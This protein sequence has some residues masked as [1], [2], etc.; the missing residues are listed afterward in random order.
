MTARAALAPVLLVLGCSA[1]TLPAPSI[2][3]VSPATMVASTPTPVTVVVDA[4]LANQVDFGQGTLIFD[5]GMVVQI[6]SQRLGSG[7]Y[8]PDGRVQ[9]TLPTV[10]PT[11][12]YLVTVTLEDGRRA[13]S[14][15]GF[16]VTDGL[17]PGGYSVDLV[18]DQRSGV[19][20]PV[21]VRATPPNAAAFGGNVLLDVTPNGNGNG[22]A[23]LAP[24]LSAAFDAGVLRQTVTVTGSGTVV[25]RVSDIQSHNGQSTPFLVRP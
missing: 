25:L 12:T 21:T 11:G 10:L 3:S 22:N 17:W 4:E 24:S 7:S 14:D 5:T 20:F 19:A 18:G 6:G 8:P 2:T 16:T 1:S 13:V 23:T 15:A 9:G